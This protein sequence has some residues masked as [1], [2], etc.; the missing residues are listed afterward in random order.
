MNAMTRSGVRKYIVIV[1][2]LIVALAFAIFASSYMSTYLART[3][4]FTKIDLPSPL[5]DGETSIEEAISSRR[6]VREYK[7]DALRLNEVAQLVWAAQGVTSKQGY[8]TTPSAGAIYPL[9]IYLV[10]GS[11]PDFAKGVYRYLPLEHALE[12]TMND[13]VRAQLSAAAFGQASIKNASVLLIITG[14]YK[15]TQKKYGNRAVRYVDMETGHAAQ[16][17]YLQC[18]SLHLGMVTIGGF[19]DELVSKVLALPKDETPL[20]IIPIGKI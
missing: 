4:G 2:G 5:L 6:S 11:S 10:N 15:K 12:K 7:P 14:S 3:H 16:N 17:L 18:V 1:A 8:R 19:S 9:N 20:Y 13:D